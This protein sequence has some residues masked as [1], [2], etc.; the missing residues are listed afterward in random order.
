MAA[1]EYDSKNKAQ[2]RPGA[3]KPGERHAQNPGKGH[4][5]LCNH[6]PSLPLANKFREQV[7]SNEPNSGPQDQQA[8]AGNS[9]TE[10]AI[11]KFRQIE[12]SFLEGRKNVASPTPAP[13]KRVTEGAQLLGQHRENVFRS[14]R[15]GPRG[16]RQI[17]RT[18]RG[19]QEQGRDEK[20][21]QETIV[22]LPAREALRDAALDQRL[23]E[24][25]AV[26]HG[27]RE[28]MERLAAKAE[29][30]PQSL[31]Q[32]PAAESLLAEGMKLGPVEAGIFLSS[33]ENFL[34]A[35]GPNSETGWRGKS[36]QLHEI[37]AKV[38]EQVYQTGSR[39]RS[40]EDEEESEDFFQR[41]SRRI[42]FR[43]VR[44]RANARDARR[45]RGST[46]RKSRGRDHRRLLR[47]KAGP[48]AGR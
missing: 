27:R 31:A 30:T 4:D 35:E 45:G 34:A 20:P 37:E 21:A 9:I 15:R 10:A 44:K 43:H 17:S 25:S 3:G 14:Q 7:R 42:R 16:E 40:R 24:S 29:Q 22:V 36:R 28:E 8:Q 41:R 32:R 38:F 11:Q 19:A 46:L 12:D 18:D 33:R 26:A 2:A 5:L 39:E 23:A 47:T 13:A 6:S 48:G 1:Q